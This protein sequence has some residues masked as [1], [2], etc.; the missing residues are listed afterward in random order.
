M[1]EKLSEHFSLDELVFSQDAVRMG[2]DNYPS[3]GV[4]ANLRVLAAGLELVRK[5]LSDKPILISSGY[6]SPIVNKFVGGSSNS[7]HMQ[8]FAADFICPGFGTPRM[9]AEAIRDS[10]LEFDQMILE[11]TWVHLSFDTRL[12]REILTAHFGGTRPIYIKGIV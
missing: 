2:L 9:V 8:G 6:R 12:R 4:V 1:P 7:A 11:G 10:T 3:T 5:V